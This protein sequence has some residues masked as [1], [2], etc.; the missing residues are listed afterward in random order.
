VTLTRDVG[1]VTMDLNSIEQIELSARG[2]TDNIVVGDLTGTGVTQVAIDLASP[3]GSGTGDGAADS[4]T[5]NATQGDDHITVLG[6]GGSLTV[7]GLPETVTISGSE[8]TDALVVAGGAG[9][10][11]LS[12]A[13]LPAGNTVLTLDGGSGNDTIIGSQGDDILLGGD[14]NDIV[15]GGRGNDTARLGAGN[16]TFIWN[17]GDGSDVVEGEAG[18]DTLVFNGANLAENFDI[19]ANGSRVR[20]TRDIGNVVM[21]LGGVEHIQLNTL[22]GADTVTVNDLTGTGVTQVAIDL[23]APAGS[24]QGDGAS[25]TVNVS[26]TAGDDT[27][28]VASSGASVLVNGLPAQVTINGAEPGNDT[29][30][31]NGQAGNDTIDA[32]RVRAGQVNLTLN[33]GAGNDTIIGSAGNDLVNGGTG[34][35]VAQLGAGDDT[36]VW[37]PGDGSDI[38]E[39]QAGNDTL[40]LN[41]ANI[42]ENIDIS[43]NGSRARLT[44]DIGNV[45][46]DLNG[47]EHIDVN[48]R[49]GADTVTVNDLTGTN[50]SNVNIDLG[51]SIRGADAPA[52]TVVINGTSGDDTI[53]V[54]NNNGVVTISGL[55]TEVTISDFEANDRI[56]ING[57]GGD[58][59]ITAS[60]LTGMLFTANG[61]DGD[62]VLIGSPG[63]D[64]LTGGNGDD[65][66]I[67]GG[68]QDVLDGGPGANTVIRSATVA[69]ANS[70]SGSGTAS[71]GAHAAS[72]AVLGQFAASSFVTAGGDSGTPITDAPPSQQQ[73]LLT[74]P[75][76]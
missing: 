1:T 69:E 62:D 43:S 18:T 4:V 36:F 52:D 66:L 45:T 24:G 49:G 11:T 35:D 60:G 53:T 56:V 12:A 10:D 74:Q 42:N 71:D 65:V 61:G 38:V 54:T 70:T 39:G 47:V 41:G 14:G 31:I 20:M 50:V 22:G 68:G 13:T 2:G 7:T 44:R 3:P 48:A 51:A 6:Q 32:S 8:A 21:D 59:V 17:P 30:V 75:H 19:E 55:S 72:L 76:A 16:D 58:D 73:P 34:N 40:L 9:N 37:N 28:K 27:I 25:D 23:S 64:I 29:L 15:T 63:N 67:G 33:G 5:V 57:L 26:G 46:M